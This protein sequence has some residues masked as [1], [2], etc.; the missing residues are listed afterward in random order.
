[1]LTGLTGTV[2]ADK[3][4]LTKLF[5]M[6]SITGMNP[7]HQSQKKLEKPTDAPSPTQNF[8]ATR[9]HRIGF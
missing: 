7:Y 1:M 6:F 2:F 9:N 5:S 8:S 4:Y 3:G